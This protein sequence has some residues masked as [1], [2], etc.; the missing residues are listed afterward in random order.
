VCVCSPRYAACNAR[1]PYC[2]PWPVR[3]YNIF[4]HYLKKRE[5]VE[6][7]VIEHKMCVFI[8]SKHFSESLLSL[9]RTERDIINNVYW[10][11]GNVPVILTF[12]CLRAILSYD[13][14]HRAV[15]S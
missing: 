4:P 6:K 7:N 13:V 10:S 14:A 1:A 3:L 9:R 8:S 2:Y 11:S 15:R 5:I 12:I